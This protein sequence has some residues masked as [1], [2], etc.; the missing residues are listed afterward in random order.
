MAQRAGATK[1]RQASRRRSGGEPPALE[2][3]FADVALGHGQRLFPGLA[4][5]KLAA[6]LATRPQIPVRQSLGLGAEL[7]KIVIGRSELEP[8]RGDRRFKDPA[9]KQNPAFRRL[10]QS[11]LALGQAVDGAID[12]AS[13]DWRAEQRVRFA[14]MNVLDAIAPTNF[15]QTNPTVLKAAIDSGGLNFVQG[16]RQLARDLRRRQL[17]PSSVDESKFEVGRDLAVT[18]GAVVLRTKAFELIQYEPQTKKVREK[19]LL[20]APQMINK[21]YIADLAPGRSLF[22]HAVRHG[23]Q[24]FVMSW[25]NPDERHTDWNFDTYCIAVLEA[26]EAVEKITDSEQTHLMGLCAGGNIAAMVAGHLAATGQQD[27]I[28]GLTLPVTVLD[29]SRAGVAGAFMDDSTAAAA[30]AESARRGYLSG[31]TLAG[32]F[33]WMRPNDMVWGYV[34]NNYLLGK[35]PP[36]FDVLYW[37]ADQT[38]MPAAL[39]RD[40]LQLGLENSL[41]RPGEMSVLGTPIDLSQV[42]VDSYLVA[43]ISDHIAPWRSAYRTTQLLGSEPR[44]VLSTSGHIV[45]IV[46]PPNNEKAKLRTNDANPPDPDEWLECASTQSGSWWPDWT[47]WLGERSGEEKDAPKQPGGGAFSILGEAPGTYVREPA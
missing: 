25:R 39:H 40:F 32:V 1:Q 29:W 47:D 20:V 42:T 3:I 11:Y 38:N 12:A 21:Y 8:D 35:P 34:V 16:A 24:V 17:L 5:I 14:A 19:P 2:T 36:P 27:R 46:N 6:K 33:A 44:F 26:L 30:V 41:A 45:A 9:W 13:L 43:A 4:G 18:P 10:C 22:E 15:P 28:A 31:R 23:Q 7:G 37:N